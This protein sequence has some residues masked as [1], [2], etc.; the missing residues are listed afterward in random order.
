MMDLP[1]QRARSLLTNNANDF[2]YRNRSGSLECSRTSRNKVRRVVSIRAFGQHIDSSESIPSEHSSLYDAA[3]ASYE[4]GS[5][6]KTP[7]YPSI[8]AADGVEGDGF[9]NI[10]EDSSLTSLEPTRSH[11]KWPVNT[12]ETIV[13]QRSASTLSRSV[14][15]SRIGPNVPGDVSSTTQALQPRTST[16]GSS[17]GVVSKSHRV[18]SFDDL[19]LPISRSKSLRAFQSRVYARSDRSSSS[20]ESFETHYGLRETPS[21]VDPA[22]PVHPP[23]VR[24]PTPPGLPSFGSRE[25]MQY[26]P[27]LRSGRGRR[28]M[29]HSSQTYQSQL[30]PISSMSPGADPDVREGTSPCCCVGVRNIFG[31]KAFTESRPVRLPPGAVARADDGTFVRGRF[32]ARQSGH[33]VG[34][35]PISRGL[36]SHPFHRNFLPA[37][38]AKDMESANPSSSNDREPGGTG[39]F[40]FT[41][42]GAA[43][44]SQTARERSASPYSSL[45]HLNPHQRPPSRSPSV[46]RN[47][48]TMGRT[49]TSISIPLYIA[50]G[51]QQ[52]TLSRI[53]E[54]IA[55]PRGS[56]G[57]RSHG[58]SSSPSPPS[59][60]SLWQR[61]WNTCI[62]VCCG[63]EAET[64]CTTERHPYALEDNSI[65]RSLSAGDGRSGMQ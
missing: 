37:A 23:P 28:F 46:P 41:R 63:L 52:P 4:S 15:P 64:E 49:T 33:G 25:A 51:N 20:D 17:S 55:M 40:T 53:P 38:R 57:T 56:L 62:S 39:Q 10:R 61:I 21:P 2:Q 12:L 26:S 6:D 27:P 8:V 36:D 50:H 34:A 5:D 11:S 35:S 65:E 54:I 30:I 42:A 9:G 44:L 16:P 13:E 7:R 24:S 58:S 14:T 1:S 32:P 47:S 19:D 45:L 59:P 29:R 18:F 48:R 3:L 60:T 43:T 22:Q 31:I